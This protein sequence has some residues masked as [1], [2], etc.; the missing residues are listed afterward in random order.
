M[1]FLLRGNKSNLG[2]IKRIFVTRNIATSSVQRGEPPLK[3]T[4]KDFD[5]V[6]RKQMDKFKKNLE[7]NASEDPYSP[8]IFLLKTVAVGFILATVGSISYGE[9]YGR[10]VR[11]N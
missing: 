10:V 3:F 5:E 4:Q 1:L 6:N 2:L 9:L 7:K 11:I 8:V